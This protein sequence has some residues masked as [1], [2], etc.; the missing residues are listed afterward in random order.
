MEIAAQIVEYLDVIS[1]EK[2]KSVCRTWS[3][4]LI[5]FVPAYSIV[6]L[7]E[8]LETVYR[9]DEMLRVAVLLQHACCVASRAVHTLVLTGWT[10]GRNL[11][12]VDE[13]S[14]ESD[15]AVLCNVVQTRCAP[16]RR[17][18]LHR[19]VVDCEFSE[20]RPYRLRCLSPLLQPAVCRH[21]LLVDYVMN[22]TLKSFADVAVL[23]VGKSG[24]RFRSPSRAPP[25]CLALPFVR[26]DICGNEEAAST[27]NTIL[28]AI[29]L[30]LPAATQS[31]DMRSAVLGL[32]ANWSFLPPADQAFYWTFLRKLLA[33][34]EPH[35]TDNPAAL[36]WSDVELTPTSALHF[37]Q[38]TVFALYWLYCVPASTGS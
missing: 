15:I 26:L 36:P 10:P 5:A 4:I 18:I 12:G 2:V 28:Q 35:N 25:L 19:S 16:L 37:S 20:Y 14:A 11:H 7:R 31:A 38:L 24:A 6:D 22:N 1:Q 32:C 9:S 33:F 34:T 30:A 8:R 13:S 17:I 29:T 21:L 27:Y 23:F 3:T